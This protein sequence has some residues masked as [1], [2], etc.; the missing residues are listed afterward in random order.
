MNRIV[1]PSL[2][3]VF[4]G[5]HIVPAHGQGVPFV[6]GDVNGDA[7]L[8]L[9]DAVEL[10][11]FMFLDG[12]NPGCFDAADT[13][14]D[15]K[16]DLADPVLIL[17]YAFVSG[18]EP[19][20]PF[21]K[22][23]HDET[24]DILNCIGPISGC[25]CVAET[26]AYASMDILLPQLRTEVGDSPRSVSYGDLNEDNVLDLVALNRDD[27]TFSVILADSSV[28]FEQAIEYEIDAST[29]SL[30]AYSLAVGDL[31]GDKILDLVFATTPHPIKVRLGNGDGTFAEP[32]N[33]SI[34]DG[35]IVAALGDLNE[36]GNLD[37]VATSA[38]TYD[39]ISV[40]LGDGD[41]TFGTVSEFA[42]DSPSPYLALGDVND[43]RFL[44]VV[45]L[46]AFGDV[47][48]HLGDGDGELGEAEYEYGNLCSPR[49][50]VLAQLNADRYLDVVT[51][52]WLNNE[53]CVFLGDGDSLYDDFT[54]VPVGDVPYSLGAM[55]LDRDDN[56][57][58]VV[59]SLQNSTLDVL[60]GLGDGS[61]EE[62]VRVGAANEP[63]GLILADVTRDA[64]VDAVMTHANFDLVTVIPGSSAG[65]FAATAVTVFEP[66]AQSGVSRIHDMDLDGDLD[67]VVGRQGFA[68]FLAQGSG[69]L[70]QS[71]IFG[72]D[73]TFYDFE[74]G[75]YDSDGLPDIAA[76]ATPGYSLHFF[77]GDG[78]GGFAD[79]KSRLLSGGSQSMTS[80]DADADG[81]LDLAAANEGNLTVDVLLGNGDG[82][83]ESGGE[84]DVAAVLYS[85]V[86][87]DLDL[88][89]DADLVCAGPFSNAIYVLEG[90]GDGSFAAATYYT[91]FYSP[92]HVAIGDLNGDC[93]LDVAAAAG[94]SIVVWIGTGDG[95]LGAT[96]FIDSEPVAHSIAIGDVN[97]DN[98][99]D[100]VTANPSA[101]TL[102][103]LQGNGDGS[104][105]EDGHYVFGPTPRFPRLADL[106]GDG[107]LDILSIN[108]VGFSIWESPGTESVAH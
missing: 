85:V 35:A 107:D 27:D 102:R 72:E 28:G 100:L 41:G 1:L 3:V 54:T 87:G 25:P 61:F 91:G 103:I 86:A 92:S 59:T 70:E 47:K 9:G 8:G 64:R 42:S 20:P 95:T 40:L 104:F 106:D 101:G 10:L 71:E 44:D 30:D 55:D 2:I 34:P 97:G 58:I 69:V 88:D 94:T 76:L 4:A 46:T 31:D 45:A 52:D 79:A 5:L 18:A 65:G 77:A 108:S 32:E 98:L 14:D 6:R 37:I 19:A 60:Y 53:L 51:I 49:G 38:E 23:G 16:L 21:P 96:E 83:F 74:V 24:S 66:A 75:D 82:T 33:R 29:E 56:A 90:N 50:F 22:C 89:G 62:M 12:P 67:V 80:L 93:Y 84:I 36:D 105:D 57:D 99:A 81:D 7:E 63:Q 68:T 78:A 13:N 17:E 15:G 73:L 43:D 39:S 48:V 26:E 11:T